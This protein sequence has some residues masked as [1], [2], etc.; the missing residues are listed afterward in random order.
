M[1]LLTQKLREK[2]PK[3]GA[4][5]NQT[6]PLAVCKFFFPD[7]HWTWY[8]TEFDGKEI[9]DG[10]VVGDFPEYG[11]F[12]LTELTSMR[13]KFGL[14]IERDLYFTPKPMSEVMKLHGL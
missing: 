8:V 9:F 4:T 12:S 6:D 7:F 11:T 3:L 5:A 1:K 10:F 13:G 14:G 2:L